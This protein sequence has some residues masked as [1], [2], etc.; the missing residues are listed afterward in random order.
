MKPEAIMD[1][2]I[3][4]AAQKGAFFEDQ[5]IFYPIIESGNGRRHSRGA[6]ANDD[7]IFRFHHLLSFAKI[8]LPSLS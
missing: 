1:A 2:L 4:N 8:S 7:Q 5:D 3:Q 6:A